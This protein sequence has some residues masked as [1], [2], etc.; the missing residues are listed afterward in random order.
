MKINKNVLYE[1]LMIF[2]ASVVQLIGF[3]ISITIE[4]FS[5]SFLPYCNII[6][7][8]I[9][10][11]CSV[12]C[13]FLVFFP[14]YNF[15]QSVVLFIQGIAMTLN[16]LM[17]LGLFL[18]FFG[19]AL[20]FCYGYFKTNK[21]KKIIFSLLP[22]F[23]SLFV[24]IPVSRLKFF[25]AWT[26]SLFLTFAFFHLYNV[27]KN[28][29]LDLFPFL[30]QKISKIS[31]PHPEKKLVLSDYKILNRQSK[32]VKEFMNGESNYKNLAETFLI[33]ESTVKREMAEIFKKLGVENA[34][35]LRLLLNQYTEI[36]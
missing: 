15:M 3:I 35:M 8:I 34:S 10:I 2:F 12:I 16:N 33:S 28:Y 6:I 1:R 7:P 11:S 24:I 27:V 36:I 26:Y 14:K 5:D 23:L 29:L 25:M 4:D 18:Y 13:L 9:N 30:A 19:I 32:L 17:F 22:L 20:L 31:L 21:C